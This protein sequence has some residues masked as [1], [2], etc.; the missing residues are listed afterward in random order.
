MHNNV[1]DVIQDRACIRQ[2]KWPDAY[3]EESRMSVIG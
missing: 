1:D 2:K 3:S